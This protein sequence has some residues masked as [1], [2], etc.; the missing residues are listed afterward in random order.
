MRKADTNNRRRTDVAP[1]R[2]ESDYDKAVKA[3][4]A[5]K[6]KDAIEQGIDEA[7]EG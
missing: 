3:V 7:E 4:K 6:Y 2:S 1:A 5:E